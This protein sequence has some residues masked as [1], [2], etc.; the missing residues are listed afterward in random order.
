M[1]VNAVSLALLLLAAGWSFADAGQVVVALRGNVDID[2]SINLNRDT[3]LLSDL[4]PEGAGNAVRAASAAIELGR[5]PALGSLR[6]FTGVQIVAHLRTHP[7]L[8]RELSVPARVVIARS[9]WPIEVASVRAAIA[10]FLAR[11]GSPFGK[12]PENA[13]LRFAAVRA[14]APNPRLEVAR[15]VRDAGRQALEFSLRC[16]DSTLCGNFLV[17]TEMNS[18]NGDGQQN[19]RAGTES[20]RQPAL[21]EAGHAATLILENAKLNQ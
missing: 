15:A 6:V 5:A 8:L 7:D 2:F 1:L 20:D 14:R 17:R 13:E 11:P 3:V 21:A 10:E 19:L 16:V 12:L 18:A 4:L 9:G